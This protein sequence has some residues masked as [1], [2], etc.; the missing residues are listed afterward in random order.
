MPHQPTDPARV[1]RERYLIELLDTTARVVERISHRL[2]HDAREDQ[3][4]LDKI[5][6]E[7]REIRRELQ[8]P[9]PPQP[10]TLT[11]YIANVFSGESITMAK[12]VLVLNVGQTSTDTITP[13]LADGVTPSNGVVSNLSIAFSDPSATVVVNGSN[14]ALVTGVAP[15]TAGPV[16]GTTSCTVLDTDGA[17]STWTQTFTVLVNA[18]VPPTQL[19]QGIANVFSTPAP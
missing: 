15:S 11:A 9:T 6:H 4:T 12:N 2:G 18:V 3:E 1:E 16:A 17:T 19:T 10:S 14:T 5:L 8:P 13:L 7:L